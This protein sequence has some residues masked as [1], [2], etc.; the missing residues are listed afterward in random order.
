MHHSTTCV[1]YG[2]SIVG[3]QV[4]H[5]VMYVVYACMGGELIVAGL[6]MLLG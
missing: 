3:L 5:V 6:N 4:M 1:A 2:F